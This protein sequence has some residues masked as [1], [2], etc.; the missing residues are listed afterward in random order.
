M[1]LANPAGAG[2]LAVTPVR[3]NLAAG[4]TTGVLTVRNDGPEPALVQLEVM[5]WSQPDGNDLLQASRD[6]LAT[7][8]IFSVPVGGSQ[9]VRVGL[10]RPVTDGPQELAYRLLLKEVPPA[11][12]SQFQGVQIALNISL[13][14][15]VLPPAAS[16]ALPV[17]RWQARQTA[18]GLWLRADNDGD[19]HVQVTGL[20]L[21]GGEPLPRF[22][23]SY[24]LPGA[25]HEWKVRHTAAVG[26]ALSLVAYTDAGPFTAQI[27]V[28]AP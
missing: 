8:P 23:P 17:L 14:M 26:S 19:V 15:F 16:A 28:T 27:V 25:R 11:P 21:A 9:V 6:L 5:R 7:P 4:Q 12:T 13:P 3:V 10:R 20:R 24:L 2:S 18:E 22:V 1:C